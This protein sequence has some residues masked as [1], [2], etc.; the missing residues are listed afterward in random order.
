MIKKLLI[1]FYLLAILFSS[2]SDHPKIHID[3]YTGVDVT[4]NLNNKDWIDVKHSNTMYY[5]SIKNK[6]KKI[7]AGKHL[8]TIKSN[9]KIIDEFEIEIEDGDKY[10]MLNVGNVMTYEYGKA[11]YGNRRFSPAPSHIRKNFFYMGSSSTYFFKSPPNSVKLRSGLGS[12]REYFKRLFITPPFLGLDNFKYEGSWINEMRNGFGKLYHNGSII[13]D[14]HWENNLMSGFGFYIF[15]NNDVFEG[16]FHLRSPKKGRLT[17]DYNPILDE[18][19]NPYGLIYENGE[20]NDEWKLDGYG[21]RV[22]K[23]REGNTQQSKY[24]GEFKNDKKDGYGK[25][26]YGSGSIFEG[27][28]D[29]CS[30]ENPYH[31]GVMTYPSGETEEGAWEVK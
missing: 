8:I 4:I 3:N 12:T 15:N 13:Y 16:T 29:C 26:W 17:Y 10:Y 30:E 24:I 9:N 5:N 25:Y 6:A 22:W 2:C 23:K 19:N 20:W 28:Y 1:P 27:F 21:E 31:V 18:Y 7:K 11:V 14:G